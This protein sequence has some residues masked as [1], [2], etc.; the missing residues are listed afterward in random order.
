M[1]RLDSAPASD[2]AA[3]AWALAGSA[4]YALAK[5]VASKASVPVEVSCTPT[6]A[7]LAPLPSPWL[8]VDSTLLVI[9]LIW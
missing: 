9:E 6:E 8:T 2:V 3:A 1:A 5:A 7:K 4:A